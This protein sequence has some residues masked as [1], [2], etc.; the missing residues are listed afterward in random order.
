MMYIED[1]GTP[2]LLTRLSSDDI[3]NPYRVISFYFSWSALPAQRS[4]IRQ[5]ITASIK[6]RHWSKGHPR[7]LIH[8]GERL[9]K[10]IEAA[11]L[12]Q[13]EDDKVADNPSIINPDE[14]RKDVVNPELYCGWAAMFFPWD[15]FPRHL[16]KE[17]YIN[18]YK[19]LRKFFK[20]RSLPEWKGLIKELMDCA[21][22]PQSVYE[23]G[24][25]FNVVKVSTMLQK[26][27]EAAH[28]IEV[29][30]LM[31]AAG[32]KRST[33]TTTITEENKQ[34]PERQ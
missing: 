5:I 12:I 24:A 19:A 3:T 31:V 26:L 22:S 23:L 9:E 29:R 20:Y 28:L 11:Y 14:I 34:E 7:I 27:V 4:N 16:T 30:E 25:Y 2:L 21:L 18:P 15:Y 10:L 32:K 17:E 13:S 1:Y 6:E 8:A 33:Y